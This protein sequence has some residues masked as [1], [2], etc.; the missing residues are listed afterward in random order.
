MGAGFVQDATDF[1]DV[2]RLMLKIEKQMVKALRARVQAGD[3]VFIEW[4]ES[5]VP[6]QPAAQQ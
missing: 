6:E 2:K 4:D 1:R 3:T 5:F